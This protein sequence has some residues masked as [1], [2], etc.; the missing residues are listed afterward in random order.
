MWKKF[1]AVGGA[2]AAEEFEELFYDSYQS[3]FS[4]KI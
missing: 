4:L 2:V 3:H 1:S